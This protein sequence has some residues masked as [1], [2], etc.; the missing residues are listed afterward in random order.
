MKLERQT[1][2]DAG[3]QQAMKGRKRMVVA[4]DGPAGAG[5]S[6]IAKRVALRLGFL[7]ID[8]GAMYRAVG[9]WA[10]R[11]GVALDDTHRL[12]QLANQ[13]RIELETAPARV[14]L[15]GEDV[16]R[17][18]RSPDVSDAASKVSAVAGVRRALVSKQRRMGVEGCVVME[19]RDIGSVVF[20]GAEVKVFLDANPVERA[21]RRLRELEEE[22]ETA[23]LE[24]VKREMEERDRRDRNRR[25]SPLVRAPDAVYVDTTGLSLDE[26]EQTILEVVRDRASNGKELSH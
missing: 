26:V 2:R 14:C 23:P 24:R 13:A 12:E 1:T 8:T 20:P 15:N 3:E 5:K 16:T 7:Y 4:I 11:A 21:A 19:G 17:A 25:D 18:I 22:G 6:T 10:L 9:L